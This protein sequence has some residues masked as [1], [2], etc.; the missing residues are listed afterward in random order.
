MSRK[1]S[2]IRCTAPRPQ[3][4]YCRLR[5]MQ[6]GKASFKLRPVDFRVLV[7]P[8]ILDGDRGRYGKRACDTEMLHGEA[9]RF[10]VGK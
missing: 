8:G 4:F 5:L 9:A 10:R 6:L 2:V 1:P 3:L 7:K